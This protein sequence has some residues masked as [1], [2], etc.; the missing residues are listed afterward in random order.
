MKEFNG[1]RLKTARTIRRYGLAE[2]ADVLGV[3]RQTVSMYESG[4]IADPGMDRIRKMSEVLEFPVGFFLDSKEE[5]INMSKGVYFRSRLTTGTRYR[6]EQEAKIG[7]VSTM[8]AFLS[9]YVSFPS[10]NLPTIY[11]DDTIED[12]AYKLREAWGLGRGPIN[13]LIYHAEQNGILVTAFST[14]TSDIDGFSQRLYIDGEE[15]YLI[16]LSKNKESA[17]RLHFDVAHELGH[18]LMHDFDD[19]IETLDPNEFREREREANEF[20]AA[21]LLPKETFI[22]DIGPHAAKFQYYIEM[23]RRWKVSIAAMLMRSKNLGLISY[24]TYQRLVRY[25]QTYG[26]RKNEPLDDEL[27]TAQPAM[28]KTAV[29][30]L[31]NG[32]V[33]TAREFVQEIS[34]NYNLTL[35]PAQIEELLGLKKGRLKEANLPLELNLKLKNNSKNDKTSGA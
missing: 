18:I 1:Q 26:L 24:D 12:M 34:M 19:N 35:Y 6:E 21:F 9:E 17:A 14:S 4:K 2:L 30:M 31:L 11:E 16:A 29:D 23:K 7:F 32:D 8:Y 15:K 10:L 3:K 27:M 25:M 28:L 13:D 5:A 33:M 22:N 20:A